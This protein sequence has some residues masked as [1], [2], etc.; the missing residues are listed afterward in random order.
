MGKTLADIASKAG[1]SQ[2]SVSR[3]INAKPGVSEDL[4]NTVI[5][6]ITSLGMPVD[7]MQ[8]NGTRLVAIIT[9]DMSNPIFPKFVT[10]ITNLLAQRGFLV[11]VCTYTPSGTSED[12]Y[13]SLLQ[14]Q[15]LAAAIFLAG[16]YDTRGSNL[17]I[18]KTLSEH[19]IPMAFINGAK[20][21]MDGLYASTD[22]ARAMNMAL[23]H[24]FYHQTQGGTQILRTASFGS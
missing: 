5:S 6:A 14:S 19:G 24:A 10:E 21:D 16:K 8:R 18:Y 20:R 13:L 3:V 1:V 23:R 2:A 12:G 9:P 15:P 7:N 22:D 17:T 11:I 4:R